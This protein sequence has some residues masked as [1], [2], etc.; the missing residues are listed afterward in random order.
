MVIKL[1]KFR[2]PF[3]GMH[4]RDKIA[5]KLHRKATRSQTFKDLGGRLR[6]VRGYIPKKQIYGLFKGTDTFSW[7]L[8]TVGASQTNYQEVIAEDDGAIEQVILNYPAGSEYEFYV[9][10]LIDGAQVFPSKLSQALRGDDQQKSYTVDIPFQRGSRIRVSQ[11]SDAGLA[12]NTAK[13]SWADITVR[14]KSR[15]RRKG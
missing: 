3:R 15:Q 1:W 14:Y 4:Q 5:T 8:R 11:I 2:H 7:R 10:I 13:S 6:K 9:Q 12:A